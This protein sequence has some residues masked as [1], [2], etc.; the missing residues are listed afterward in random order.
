MFAT[1][2]DIKHLEDKIEYLAQ[3]VIKQQEDINEL[4]KPKEPNYM[5]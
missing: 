2:K 3:I 4:K 1:K 5:A